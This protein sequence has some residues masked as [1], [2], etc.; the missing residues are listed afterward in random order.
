MNCRAQCKEE[1]VRRVK[2]I[3]PLP[4]TQ[5]RHVCFGG[6]QIFYTLRG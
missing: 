2:G 1:Y 4:Q 5:S 6:C 3:V